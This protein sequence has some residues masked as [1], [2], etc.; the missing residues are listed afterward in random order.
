MAL[1][2]LAMVDYHPRVDPALPHGVTRWLDLWAAE[3]GSDHA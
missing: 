3:G 2:M 1:R